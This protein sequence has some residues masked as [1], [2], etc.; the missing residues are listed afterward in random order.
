MEKTD[1]KRRTKQF[2]L[3]AMKMAD[4]LPKNRAGRVI[5]HQLIRAG[6]AVGA[7]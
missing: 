6:A 4:A 5:G 7:N 2:A 1:L 3:R